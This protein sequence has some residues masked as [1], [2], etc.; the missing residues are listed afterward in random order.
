LGVFGASLVQS[1]KR[2]ALILP[3]LVLPLAVPSVIFG[4]ITLQRA[5]TGANALATFAILAGITLMTLALV[6]LA[7]AR[8]IS[9][10]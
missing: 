4:T 5:T 7:A 6:P 8:A 3:V 10:G 2:G 1:M 9:R